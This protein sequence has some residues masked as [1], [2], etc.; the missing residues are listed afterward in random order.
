MSRLSPPALLQ[1]MATAL[2][3]SQ[4]TSS[5]SSSYE[6]IALLVHAYLSSLAFRLTGFQEEKPSI[7]EC[8]TLA[9]Q[10]P[11]QWNDGFG[12]LG[13]VYKHKQS[14][15][16]F[17]FRIDKMGA[18]VEVRGLAVGAENIYRFERSVRDVVD[19]KNLP[20]KITVDDAGNEDRSDLVEKLRKTFIS[21]DVIAKLTDDLR[22]NIVQKL[23]PKLQSEDYEETAE[24]EASATDDRRRQEAQN[25]NRPFASNDPIRPYPQPPHNPL[26]EMAR[27]R[28]P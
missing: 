3:A 11:P 22:V 5:L 14:A 19:A 12:S 6:V 16:T 1:A 17:V 23:I 2:P 26:P 9:P 8:E 24:A 21:E 10:L 15:M 4:S 13:F 18:K 7:P 28:P 25:P 20:V 27:P